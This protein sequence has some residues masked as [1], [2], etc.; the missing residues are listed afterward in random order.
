MEPPV[1]AEKVLPATW[2]EVLAQVQQAL[3]QAEAAAR[4]REQA[5]EAGPAPDP[6]ADDRETTWRQGQE[7]LKERLD[8]LEACAAKA[9]HNA[10]EADAAITDGEEV[11]RRWLA[12]CQTVGQK[13]AER[14]AS[15][16]G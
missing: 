4:A 7:R 12:A 9:R 3:Q 16:V 14:A 1:P 10:A 13:L 6:M 11:I 5:L 8:G 15:G 2:P